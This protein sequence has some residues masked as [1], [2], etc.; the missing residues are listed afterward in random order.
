MCLRKCC[1]YLLSSNVTL[2]IECEEEGEED[3][4]ATSASS[5][6]ENSEVPK[7]SGCSSLIGLLM[8]V[9]ESVSSASAPESDADT[10]ARK[11][12]CVCNLSITFMALICGELS[13]FIIL[14]GRS[15][16]VGLIHSILSIA[17]INTW[18]EF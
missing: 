18:V 16:S 7:S 14:S 3:G 5:Q 17:L 1:L 15:G 13:T 2:F 9:S 8:S 4:S 11:E 6:S 10:R 12:V